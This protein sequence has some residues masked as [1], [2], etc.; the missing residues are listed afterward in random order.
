M[1]EIKGEYNYID[2]YNS[3]FTFEMIRAGIDIQKLVLNVHYR[4]EFR[5]RFSINIIF[6]GVPCQIECDEYTFVDFP[7]SL[8]TSCG[9][10]EDPIENIEGSCKMNCLPY[11]PHCKECR[12]EQFYNED[13]YFYCMI[14]HI[15]YRSIIV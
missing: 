9:R 4:N 8:E 6:Y 2:F 10:C 5:E 7:N 12:L 1:V 13:T 15:I 11:D 14:D 3:G